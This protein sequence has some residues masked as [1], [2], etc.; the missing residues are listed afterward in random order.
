MKKHYPPKPNDEAILWCWHN[1]IEIYCI[2]Q[3]SK[4]KTLK[5]AVKNKDKV[6]LGKKVYTCINE[7]AQKTNELYTQIYE[8]NKNV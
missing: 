1:E 8:K 3:D 2:P 4:G 6:T 5:I 7:I